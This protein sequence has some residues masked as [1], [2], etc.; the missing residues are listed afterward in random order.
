MFWPWWVFPD[1]SFACFHLSYVPELGP[2]LT[3]NPDLDLTPKSQARVQ[4]DAHRYFMQSPL[5]DQIFHMEPIPAK[6]HRERVGMKSV[7]MCP[8][9][10]AHRRSRFK[11]FRPLPSI[12]S[13][14][15]TCSISNLLI[16]AISNYLRSLSNSRLAPLLGPSFFH[17]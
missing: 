3:P 9:L 4:K 16:Q 1:V 11:W 2:D 6:K 17:V 15:D 8:A 13:Q 5:D 12:H 14:R 10:V 7:Q